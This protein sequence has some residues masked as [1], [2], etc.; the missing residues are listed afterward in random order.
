MATPDKRRNENY[1]CGLSTGEASSMIL[2]RVNDHPLM[3]LIDSGARIS[4]ISWELEEFEVEKFETKNAP[5]KSEK[6]H[7]FLEKHIDDTRRN[8]CTNR[9]LPH[10]TSYPYFLCF[11]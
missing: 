10:I 11:G 1:L 7:V 6:S 2:A 9:P 4:V 8:N 3:V 5:H